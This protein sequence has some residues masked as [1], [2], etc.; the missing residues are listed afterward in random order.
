[1][2][3][4]SIFWSLCHEADKA[5]STSITSPDHARVSNLGLEPQKN[6]SGKQAPQL[7]TPTTATN[8]LLNFDWVHSSSG[9]DF[10]G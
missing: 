7:P 6:R 3:K 8:A 9:I 1:M 2:L 4:I 5:L 10:L